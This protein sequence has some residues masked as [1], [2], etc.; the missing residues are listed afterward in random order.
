MS[1]L[2]GALDCAT[3]RFCCWQ[4][5]GFRLYFDSLFDKL[6]VRYELALI[7]YAKDW[8]TGTIPTRYFS[9]SDFS[10]TLYF[11]DVLREQRNIHFSLHVSVIKKS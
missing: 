4:K 1:L 8:E 10:L 2:R 6:Q 3:R 11:L 7:Q 5:G 9:G